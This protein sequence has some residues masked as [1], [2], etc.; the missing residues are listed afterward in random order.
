AVSAAIA[1]RPCTPWAANALRSAWM[2][3][4]PPESE[5]AMV[6]AEQGISLCIRHYA[7]PLRAGCPGSTGR[8]VFADVESGVSRGAILMAKRLPG[9]DGV[10]AL[11]V[12][13]VVA[14]HAAAFLPWPD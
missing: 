2:P 13:M 1:D 3:A 12:G 14:G 11:A 4:P 9:L 5:P 7:A 6:S 8:R 10:R